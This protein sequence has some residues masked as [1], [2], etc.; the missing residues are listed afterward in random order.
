MYIQQLRIIIGIDSRI[1]RNFKARRI[2]GEFREFRARNYLSCVKFSL[3]I[4]LNFTWTLKILPIN[5]SSCCSSRTSSGKSLGVHRV[6]MHECCQP[7]GIKQTHNI[8]VPVFPCIYLTK[9]ALKWLIYNLSACPWLGCW[10]PIRRRSVGGLLLNSATSTNPNNSPD[11]GILIKYYDFL[12]SERESDNY[13]S[14][15]SS[16][17]TTIQIY[18]YELQQLF[19]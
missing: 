12:Q 15:P 17:Q 13:H 4:S 5:I 7:N 16:H 19:Q 18:C 9:G 3:E 14:H 11:S 10:P 1:T 6:Q 2:S 8:R